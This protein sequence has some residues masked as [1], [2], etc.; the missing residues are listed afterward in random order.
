[1]NSVVTTL[2]SIQGARDNDHYGSSVAMATYNN[3]PCVIVGAVGA[4]QSANSTPIDNG[5]VQVFCVNDASEVAMRPALYGVDSDGEFGHSVATN[6]DASVIAV[7]AR[8]SDQS[9]KAD[10]G[11]VRV[12]SLILKCIVSD[13]LCSAYISYLISKLQ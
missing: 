9:K 1:M 8:F 10:N 6:S 13:D 4:E 7:G 2:A 11:L 3:N 5:K 12:V